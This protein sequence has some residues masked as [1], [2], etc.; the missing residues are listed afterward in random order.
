MKTSKFSK[1]L[2]VVLA[3][4]MFISSVPAS[5]FA[6]EE[7]YPVMKAYPYVNAGSLSKY[8][9]HE[10]RNSI[11]TATF[12]DTIDTAG[13]VREWD[14]SASADTGTV[15]A[16]IKLNSEETAA[17]GVDRYDLYIGGEGGVTANANSTQVFSLF[18]V[19]KSVNGL[20]NY[21]TDNVT[22]LSWFFE[23][24][25]SLE[26][27]D[28]SSFNTSKV[29]NLSYFMIDCNNLKSVDFSGWDTSN[30]TTTHSMFKNCYEL[31]SLDLSSFNT[32]KITTMQF[33]FYKCKKLLYIYAGD[34]WTT[35][36]IK[37]INEG[38][39]NCCYAIFNVTE[40]ES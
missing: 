38:V 26:Y 12:V 8:E 10:Y 23:G 34:G 20:E 9:Y 16:W 32:S 28:L 40:E 35:E 2:S 17:A 7:S 14:I 18:P 11:V 33:M 15:K 25:K 39:F 31:V 27:V 4:L 37:N 24:C 19:L 22:N 21:H 36:S 3:V 6:I 29:T 30:V 5:V 1:I 13:A